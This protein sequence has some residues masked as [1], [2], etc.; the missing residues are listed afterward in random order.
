MIILPFYHLVSENPPAHVRHLFNIKNEK[1]FKQDLEYL[2]K[3]YQPISL[4][5]FEKYDAG[6]WTPK[7]QAF[8]LSFDDGLQECFQIIAPILGQFGLP[9][10]FFLN[11][12]FVNNESMSQ[13]CKASLLI[14][15]LQ[16]HKDKLSEGK[17]FWNVNTTPALLNLL[18]T[19]QDKSALDVFAKNIDLNF[20]GY[21]KL[22]KPYLDVPMVENMAQRGFTFGAHSHDHPHMH[23]LDDDQQLFQVKHSMRMLQQ[24]G[25]SINSF[26]FPFTDHGI[27]GKS[28]KQLHEKG[29]VSLSFG[30]SGI[31]PDSIAHHYQRISMEAGGKSASALVRQEKI[32]AFIRKSFG[33]NA[34]SANR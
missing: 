19:Q 26:A 33:K 32:R 6:E 27:S 34:L 18:R 4:Q 9:A 10:T 8:H 28:I 16:Q 24:I 23:L 17:R 11:S 5:D 29:I 21:L 12:A 2:C 31:R 14:C 25:L 13:M 7:K 30:T 15:E 20:D 1:Q 22:H 3:H